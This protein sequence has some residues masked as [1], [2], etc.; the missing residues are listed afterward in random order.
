ME[1]IAS[2]DLL[3]GKV[4]RLRQGRYDD[5]TVYHDDAV[6]LAAS[7]AG[8]A[9]RLHVVDLEGARDGGAAQHEL[10]LRVARAF[11]GETQV[12]GGIR[13]LERVRAWLEAG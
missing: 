4:V 3:G 1:L 8:R 5:V 2:I 11:G 12:G 6:A 9:R 7:W 13:S 10:A